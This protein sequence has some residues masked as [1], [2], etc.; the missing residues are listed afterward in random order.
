[1]K[2][3]LQILNKRALNKVLL[4]SLFFLLLIVFTKSSIAQ[5][6]TDRQ[7]ANHYFQ[8][9]EYDKAAMYFELLYDESPNDYYYGYLFRCYIELERYKD[10]EKLVK[11]QLKK[12]KDEPKYYVDQ[13]SLYLKEGDEEKAKK[14]FET[15]INNLQPNQNRIVQLGNAFL[16][17]DQTDYALQT[18][19]QGRK[20][21]KERYPF[22]I[23]IADVYGA[24]RKWDLMISEYLDLIEVQESYLQTV[25]NAIGRTV[26]FEEPNRQNQI[27]RQELLKRVQKYPNNKTYPEML[28][29]TYLQ[30]KDFNGAYIQIKAID[31]RF[32][33]DGGRILALAKTCATNGNYDLSIEAYNYLIDT[34]GK[35]SYYYDLAK[36]SLLGVL[37]K[38]I[39]LTDTYTDSDLQE[40]EKQYLSTIKELGKSNDNVDM[41]LDLA[42]LEAYYV[43][44]IDTAIIIL[45]DAR[46]LP[47]LKPQK[48]AEC[49]LALGDMLIIKDEV[50]DALLLY[51]Q[52]DKDYKYD[53]LGERAKL[54]SA[55]TYYY[56]GSFQF[57][58]GQ[59]DVLKGSTSKLIANDAMELSRLITDNSTVDTTIRPLQIYARADLLF[60]QNKYDE[61]IATLDTITKEYPGHAL[62]DEVLYLK[63]K[64]A[65][66]QRDYEKAAKELQAIVDTYSY[67]ILADNALFQL[68]ELYQNKFNDK[69]KA[70]ELYEAIIT[71][72][73]GSLYVVEARKR[74]RELRG[75]VVN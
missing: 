17:I 43:H 15:A 42:E 16:K 60:V 57:A 68:A 64:V 10:A 55:K 54:K 9:A 26:S 29:W 4:G 19:Y 11:Q 30:L 38:K 34:K 25:Q 32:K 67:D 31:K 45:N 74:F 58:K 37:K 47:A 39:T 7:L 12:Y 41:L 49:K 22:N 73:S 66:K 50:W 23:E 72:Y 62:A 28:I 65:I 69:D 33:E 1:M 59:L 63:H 44:N 61:V 13:G 48:L 56:T 6:D 75:D 46:E 8:A 36:I 35:Q 52:V 3:L 5:D 70:M 53:E 71:N 27:L 18:Y 21:L 51:A 20:L 14:S 40:L 24:Q 2:S